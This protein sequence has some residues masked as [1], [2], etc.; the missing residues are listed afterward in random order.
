MTVAERGNRAVLDMVWRDQLANVRVRFLGLPQHDHLDCEIALDPKRPIHSIDLRLMCYPSYF[1]S[2]NHRDGARRIRTPATL[3]EQG[4]RVALSPKDN[5]WA[6]YYD[7]IFDVAKGEGDGPCAMLLAPEEP[8]EL[9]VDPGSYA[10]TTRIRYPAAARRMHLA[11]WDFKGKSNAEA[12]ARLQSGAEQLRQELGQLDFTP[13]PIRGV[14]LASL[15]L[16]V[17]RAVQSEAVRAALG[18]KT[19]EIQAWL[20]RSAE[21]NTG[22]T[23]EPAGIQA[24]STCSSRCKST[25]S[26]PGKSSW[27][28]CS[29]GCKHRRRITSVLVTLRVTLSLSRSERVRCRITRGT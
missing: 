10:V 6:V 3:V 1:T 7:E 26:S 9:T 25:M 17:H 14:D 18:T 21:T 4:K 8:A 28:S 22:K 11:F 16:D 20:D 12:M 13:V 5:W 23:G 24:Q 29:Q 27:R 15:R 19:A 2:F